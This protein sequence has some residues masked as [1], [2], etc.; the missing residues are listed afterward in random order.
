MRTRLNALSKQREFVSVGWCTSTPTPTLRCCLARYTR[1]IRKD[2]T[3]NNASRRIVSRLRLASNCLTW[4]LT[5]EATS[6]ETRRD[7]AAPRNTVGANDLVSRF[8]LR[9]SVPILRDRSV[10]LTSRQRNTRLKSARNTAEIAN[11]IDRGH[12]FGTTVLSRVCRSF[13]PS[14][15]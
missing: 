14:V 1:S 10:L 9:E 13:A 11:L 3:S 8:L 7:P 5:R 4:S 2:R 6:R 15:T 12:L